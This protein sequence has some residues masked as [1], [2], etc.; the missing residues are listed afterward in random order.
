MRFYACARGREPVRSWL[1][2]LDKPD[3]QIIGEDILTVEFGWPLGLP[4]CASLGNELWEVRSSVSHGHIARVIF[5]VDGDRMV[6]LNG[7][8]KKTQRTPRHE[9]DLALKRLAEYRKG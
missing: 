6:L 2:S 8:I 7:L 9:I 1:Q 4:V 5:H 3:R